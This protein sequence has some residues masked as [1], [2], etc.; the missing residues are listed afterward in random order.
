MKARLEG[1][2]YIVRRAKGWCICIYVYMYITILL[3]F[4]VCVLRS[5]SFFDFSRKGHSHGHSH[6]QT[7]CVLFLIFEE[8]Y[9]FLRFSKFVYMCI[10]VYVYMCICVY[11]HYDPA[12]FFSLR[13]T[14]EVIFVPRA[15][16]SLPE[17]SQSPLCRRFSQFSIIIQK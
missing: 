7:F 2:K 5:I 8:S 3:I 6:G 11:V 10:C 12:H 1:N 9:V 14:V 4:S 16:Q 15:S 13:I 17:P